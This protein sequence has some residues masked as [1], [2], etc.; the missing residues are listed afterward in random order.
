MRRLPDT[1]NKVPGTRDPK[2]GSAT[3][4][5]LNLVERKFTA[6]LRTPLSVRSAM[7]VIVT[8]TMVS[9]VAGGVLIWLVDREEFPDLGTGLWWA[10]QTVTTVGYG[11]VVPTQTGGRIIAGLI[12]LTGIA[13]VA[14]ITAA[15]TAALIE[16]ARRRMRPSPDV[17]LTEIARRLAAIEAALGIASERDPE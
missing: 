1:P 8:A 4:A 13:F 7:G 15:V 2:K 14:V 6:F 17:E 3:M 5:R 16:T 11:D 10:L 9:V 12:M